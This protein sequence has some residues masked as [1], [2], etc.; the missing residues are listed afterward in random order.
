MRTSPDAQRQVKYQVV[1][2]HEV[3]LIHRRRKLWNTGEEEDEIAP[4]LDSI[5]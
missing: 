3:G 5:D 1:L 4:R 2:L